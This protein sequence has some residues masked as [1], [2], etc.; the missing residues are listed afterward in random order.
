MKEFLNLISPA[1]K[2]LQSRDVGYREAVPVIE[3]VISEVKKLRHVSSFDKFCHSSIEKLGES[4]NTISLAT[5]KAATTAVTS[6]RP[7]RNKQ[8]S[9]KL[10]EYIVTSSIGERNSD[11]KVEVKSTYYEVIDIFLSEMNERF[12]ENS[13]ILLA[14]SDASEFSIE[15]LKPLESLGLKL[16]PEAELKVAKAF[17]DRKK[18][19]HDEER[20]KQK[21]KTFK[22]RFNLLH[23][24]YGMRDAF[25][26][27]YRFMA[28][29]DTFG[30]STAIC[31][32]TFSALERV[33][34]P[35][36][37]NMGNERLRN[38]TF[39]AFEHKKLAQIPV[40]DVLKRFNSNPLRRVQLF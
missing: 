38:L 31:E 3:T 7:A 8:R 6:K 36:R 29:I 25:P 17:I 23:E 12:T 16:P 4:T 24:L 33:G 13:D 40:D 27:V 11:P 32:C 28:I 34:S 14:I 30:C 21:D 2:I 19:K 22:T 15:K 5:S 20:E 10:K 39:L 1:D 9:S 26:E 35:R 18:E 37:V